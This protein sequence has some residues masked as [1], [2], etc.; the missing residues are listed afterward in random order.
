MEGTFHQEN[1]RDIPPVQ[2]VYKRGLPHTRMKHNPCFSL[3][4]GAP[5]SKHHFGI[6]YVKICGAGV[7]LTERTL[8]RL[9]VVFVLIAICTKYIRLILSLLDRCFYL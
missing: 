3:R 9:A 2:C 1:G 8:N 5:R 6:S 7:L 4:Y